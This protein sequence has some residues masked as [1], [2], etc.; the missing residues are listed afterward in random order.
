M[1]DKS[2]IRRD[3][4][5]KRDGIAA[6]ERE[7][8]DILIGERIFSL[9]EFREARVVFYFASFRSE[10]STLSQIKEALRM[11]KKIVLP[12]VDPR[13]KVLKLYEIKDVGE[14]S[15]GCM[16][17]PEPAVPEERR[18]EIDDVDLV[19][20]PGAAFDVRGNRIG[21]GGGYYDKLLSGMKKD[22]PLIAVAYEEQVVD[23]VPVEPHDIRV[24]MIVTDRRLIRC[25]ET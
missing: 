11:G 7:R 4:L 3:V 21:Y 17:I 5:R 22:A 2:R 14:L 23:R 10:V 12:R 16:G 6:S 1:D 18:R 25:K 19:I 15:P 9:P 13:L 24:D 8:R 20:M